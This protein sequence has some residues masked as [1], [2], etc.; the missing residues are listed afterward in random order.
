MNKYSAI[1]LGMGP[2]SLALVRALGRKGIPVYG[3]GLAK[4]E[5]ALS[6]RYCKAI[7]IADPRCEPEKMLDLL[8]EFGR[9]NHNDNKLILYPTGDECVAFIGDNYELLSQ[10]FSFSKLNQQIAELFLDKGKFYNACIKYE[11][12]APIAFLPKSVE[13]LNY[14][15]SSIKYPCIVKPKYYHKWAM[16]HGLVKGIVCRTSAELLAVGDDYCEGLN[17]FIIQEILDGPETDI[18]VVAAYYDRNSVPYGIFVGN[19]IRQ[20]P[21]GFGTT[22]MMR[23]ANKPEL[24]ALSNQFM[25]KIGYQGLCD[26]EYKLDHRDNKFKIIEINPRLGRWYGIVEAAGHDT[27]YYSFLDLSN[28]PIPQV[29]KETKEVTWALT[30]R[31]FP[32]ILQS[33]QWSLF[34]AIRSYSGPKTWCIWAKDDIKPFFAYFGEMFV[35]G[36]KHYCRFGKNAK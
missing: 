10:Y 7:G 25:Q 29:E 32:A 8:V 28:Q 1:V 17:Q 23:T 2:T 22:T 6:S 26:I 36:F 27:I 20:Y 19:K 15:A 31:D 5:L 16:K 33:K 21:V 18:F 34:S 14:I 35:K 13:E 4:C 24:V 9:D 30:S 11:L 12:P 3:I